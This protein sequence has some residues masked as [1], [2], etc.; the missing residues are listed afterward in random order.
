MRRRVLQATIA[1]VTVAVVLLGI[2]LAFYGARL[3]RDVELRDLA[4]RAAA[5]GRQVETRILDHARPQERTAHRPLLDHDVVVEGVVSGL[6]SQAVHGS[7]DVDRAV[8]DG[9]VEPA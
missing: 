1:A 6:P 7:H 4:D 5:L 3:V 2:P 8:E 9:H